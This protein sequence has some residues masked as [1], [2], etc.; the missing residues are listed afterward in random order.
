MVGYLAWRLAVDFIKPAH[1]TLLGMTP[2][3]IACLAGLAWYAPHLPR[4]FGLRR[5][6][7]D[8]P[9]GLAPSASPSP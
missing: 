6:V 1:V 2:I 7:R 3:Q 4:L 9:P 8:Q 5:G